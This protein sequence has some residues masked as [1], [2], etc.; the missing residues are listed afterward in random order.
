MEICANNGNLHSEHLLRT[1]GFNYPTLL[2]VYVVS[3]LFKKTLL[4]FVILIWKWD[5]FTSHP[6][7]FQI[8]LNMYNTQW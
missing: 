2:C 4:P 5:I 6:E 3:K 8:I 1:G 7:T